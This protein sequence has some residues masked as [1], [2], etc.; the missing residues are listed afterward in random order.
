M[1]FILQ[2]RSVQESCINLVYPKSLNLYRFAGIRK[3]DGTSSN[4]LGL[5]ECPPLIPPLSLLLLRLWGFK[6]AL[7]DPCLLLHQS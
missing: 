7:E 6:K 3:D 1:I 2:V 5:A 4:L